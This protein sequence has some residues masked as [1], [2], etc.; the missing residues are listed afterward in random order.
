MSLANRVLK[1][2]WCRVFGLTSWVHRFGTLRERDRFGVLDR[3]HYAYGVLRGADIAKYFG[4]TA[5]TICEFGVAGGD[6]LERLVQ[7]GE[8]VGREVGIDIRVVGF[9]SAQGLPAPRGYKDH[10]EIWS[11][12][13]F[14]P[15]SREDL[16]RRFAGRA[17]LIV[18]D[19]AET[20]AGFVDSLTERAPLGFAAFDMDLYSSTKQSLCSLRG[21]AECYLPAVSLY[22]DDVGFFFANRACGVLAAIDEF[23]GDAARRI[24]DRDHSLPG[25]RV[26]HAAPW[27][28]RM[29]A[30]HLLDHEV[31]QEPTNRSKMSIEDH[32]AF[33]KAMHL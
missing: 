28:A 5:M 14:S 2:V 4:H 30:C 15:R 9:D 6:G 7:L 26:Q 33:M 25:R 22:F 24:V 18:G 16:E 11:Q 10:P 23:N 8:A 32:H 20:I 3:P 17:E 27:Y 19:V 21:P 1:S 13:D 12:G 31:R 29:Y